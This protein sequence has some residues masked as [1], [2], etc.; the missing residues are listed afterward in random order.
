[1]LYNKSISIIVRVEDLF[2][3]DNHINESGVNKLREIKKKYNSEMY[4]IFED[5][6]IIDKGFELFGRLTPE[7]SEEYY[8][9]VY[10]NKICSSKTEDN[11]EIPL[12][13][14]I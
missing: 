10:L 14:V 12:F 4:I 5:D 1:M 11:R 8:N 2:P 7:Q 6:Y 3:P 13:W 9:L